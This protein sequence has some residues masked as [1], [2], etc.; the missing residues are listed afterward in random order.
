MTFRSVLLG[1][2]GA[3]VICGITYFNDAIL[4]QSLI[5]GNHLPIAVY[6]PL[7][8]FLLFANPLLAWF[9][10]ITKGT[11]RW[12]CPLSGRELAVVVALCLAACCVPYSSL[13]RLLTNLVMLPHHYVRTETSWR[14]TEPPEEA[15]DVLEYLPSA[16]QPD[17]TVEG[18]DPLDGFVQGLREGSEGM[19]ISDVPWQAWIRPLGFWLPLFVVFSI[20]LIGLALAVHRHWSE[21][22]HLPYPVVSFTNALLPREGGRGSPLLG[23]RLFWLGTGGVVFFHLNNYLYQWYP[24]YLIQIPRIYNFSP[25]RT[26]CRTFIRGGGWGLLFPKIYFSFIA[27]AYLLATDVSLAVGL[28]PFLFRYAGGIL[29]GYGIP[30]GAGTRFAPR[31][32]RGIVYGG[33]VGTFLSILFTGRYYFLNLMRRVCFLRS[34]DPIPESAIWGMRVFLVGMV[35]FV[36]DLSLVGLD[37]QLGVLYGFLAVVICLVMGRIIAETGLFFIAPYLYPCVLIYSF[38]GER[39]VGPR[40]LMIMFMVTCAFLIDPRETLMPYVV[41]GLKLVDERR[42]RTGRTAVLCTVAI[43]FGLCVAAPLT[44]YFQYDRGVNWNDGWASKMVPKFAPA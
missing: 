32:D 37:W 31:I 16:M 15:G 13:L 43:V 29:M 21:H 1:L 7:L 20:A 41:N 44:L 38:L 19:R 35:V 24:E 14:W 36:F 17:L 10:R 30:M 9:A 6:G 27:I 18:T 3:G 34:S 8:L 25:L 28:G 40:A 5:V 12:L 4:R 11:I 39:S 22:E 26:L 2:L 23:S 42:V 33:Y